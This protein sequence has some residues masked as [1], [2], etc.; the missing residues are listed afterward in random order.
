[1]SALNGNPNRRRGNQHGCVVQDLFG[2]VRELHLLLGVGIVQKDVTMRQAVF[3]DGVGVDHGGFAALTLVFELVHGGLTGARHTLVGADNHALNGVEGVKR[4]EHHDQLDGGAVGIGDDARIQVQR[5]G[6]DL[7]DHQGNLG[8]H[9]PCAGVVDDVAAGFG[10]FR[11]PGEGGLAPRRKN[12]HVWLEGHGFF[13]S[14]HGV[15]FSLP[16]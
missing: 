1:M 3:V 4:L 12:G 6:V 5:L 7:R 10:K 16:G 13:R 8:L 15:V 2:F 11:S 9:A 14:H